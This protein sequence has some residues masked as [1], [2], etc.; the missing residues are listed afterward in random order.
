M[1]LLFDQNLSFRLVIALQAEYPDS[2]H[3]RDVG[4]G[5]AADEVVWRYAAEH[6]Y[7]VVTKDADFHQRSF[8]FGA[9]PKVVWLRCGNASTQVIETLLHRHYEDLLRF[10]ADEEGSFLVIE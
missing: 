10:S 2:Q 7:T 5:E 1:K 4:L 3:V 6:G 9:P 8:L